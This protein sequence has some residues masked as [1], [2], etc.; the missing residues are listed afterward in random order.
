MADSKAVA[1]GLQDEPRASC[2]ARKRKEE[3]MEGMSKGLRN[4]PER[5]LNNCSW[6]NWSNKTNNSSITI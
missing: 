2:S 1:G 4:Q 6:K 5:A 3:K